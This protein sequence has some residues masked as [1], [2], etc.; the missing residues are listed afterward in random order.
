MPRCKVVEKFSKKGYAV[1]GP[2]EAVMCVFPGGG[3]HSDQS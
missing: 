2:G 3:G 1:K